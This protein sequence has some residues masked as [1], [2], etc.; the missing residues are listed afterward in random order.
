MRCLFTTLTAEQTQGTCGFSSAATVYST[1]R[2]QHRLREDLFG[3]FQSNLS[4]NR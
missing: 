4:E 1:V 3:I 2:I